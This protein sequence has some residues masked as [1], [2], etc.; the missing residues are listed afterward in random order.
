MSRSLPASC[1]AVLALCLGALPVG[2]Q[3]QQPATTA[4]SPASSAASSKLADLPTSPDQWLNSGPL[5][6][7]SL[8]GKGIVF[9]YFEEQCPTCEGRWPDILEVAERHRD[10]PVVFVAVNSGN[11][12]DQIR[13]YLKRNN[14]DWPVIVD[15]DRSFEESS[16]G[17]TISLQNIYQARMLT[18]KGTWKGANPD[19]LDNA[20]TT[21][22][23]GGSWL[24]DPTSMPEDL[25]RA[26]H[27]VEI[28]NYGSA[29]RAIMRAGREGDGPTKVAAKQLFDVVQ[30]SM[31]AD[32]AAIGQQLKSGQN[33]PAY[34][35][36]EQFLA[37]YD[38][39]PMHPAVAEKHEQVSQ[40]EEVQNENKAAKKLAAAIRT[41]S[42]NT[43][44][45]V[46]KAVGMLEALIE[47][48]PDTEAAA[49]AQKLLEQVEKGDAASSDE[50]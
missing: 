38:G 2:V 24:V 8:Q 50:N 31:N 22:S 25:R 35:A 14:I 45:S 12:P 37:K 49:D 18:A 5:S 21:A 13:G 32:L 46:K 19:E 29:S 48:Y 33:W 10:E 34:Q 40:M 28:S 3:G 16:L 36:L 9:Y 41:G 27:E 44:S 43:A 6:L 42:R 39:Y 11:S 4:S 26:W 1:A 23:E 20:A 47:D 30:A 15:T 7:D 17:M